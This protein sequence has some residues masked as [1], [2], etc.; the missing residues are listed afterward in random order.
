MTKVKETYKCELCG[1]CVE[2]KEAGSGELVCC[3]QPM[4]KQ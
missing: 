2:V 4:E 1:N 3:D